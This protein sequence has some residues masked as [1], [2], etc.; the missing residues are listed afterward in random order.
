MQP[1]IHVSEAITEITNRL[2]VQVLQTV[3]NVVQ[4]HTQA[5]QVSLINVVV[6]L[7]SNTCLVG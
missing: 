3:P 7:I 5:P 1:L 4:E 2:S 6:Q